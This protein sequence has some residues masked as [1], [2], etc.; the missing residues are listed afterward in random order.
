[1]DADKIKKVLIIRQGA[2]GD[3][4]HTTEVFRSIKRF[5]KDIE[6]HYLT[7]KIPAQLLQYD[8]DVDR[9][10]LIEKK[11][12]K[13]IFEF[14]K[15][16][17]K[18]KYDLIINLQPSIKFKLLS[19]LSNPKKVVT[20]KKT[21][22]EHAVENFFNT[23]QKAFKTLSLSNEL[24]I[25]IP[26]DLIDKVKPFINQEKITIAI[27]TQTGP[28]R[29]GRKWEMK[30]FEQLIEQLKQTF[31]YQI[32]IIGSKEDSEKVRHLENFGAEILAGKLSLPETACLLSQ[33]D[34]VVSGDTGPLHIASAV[35]KP[36]CIGL[37]GS[38]PIKRTGPWG[39]KHIAISSEM[40]CVPCNRRKCK[41]NKGEFNPCM[42][43]IKPEDVL[44]A[45][46]DILG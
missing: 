31:D 9:I 24:V 7:T 42:Q 36:L 8:E 12:Y 39:M 21:F 1:M 37:F 27:N 13:S 20:Y 26:K 46:K 40:P 43:A 5:N 3:V 34:V 15:T 2:I 19:L 32:L 11:D 30:N 22:K 45:V 16:L 14:S 10:L 28:V 18:E 38:M 6:I 44:Q 29:C 41:Y 23:A 4:V 35:G 25:N 17:K 33:C